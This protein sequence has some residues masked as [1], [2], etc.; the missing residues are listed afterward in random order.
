[1]KICMIVPNAA[2]KGGIAAVVNGYRGSDLEKKHTVHYVESYCD[3]IE[4]DDL[5]PATDLPQAGQPRRHTDTPSVMRVILFEF[6]FGRR[7]RS[8]Q[9]HVAF[10]NIIELRQFIDACLTDEFPYLRDTRVI[11]SISSTGLRRKSMSENL[12]IIRW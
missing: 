4:V 11:L 3:G 5:A 1:M 9:A 12:R 6:V 2:V 8:D 10:H 7:P